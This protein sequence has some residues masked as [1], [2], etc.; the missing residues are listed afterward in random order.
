[1][2]SNL[3]SQIVRES[4]AKLNL[5][6][7]PTPGQSVA[8]G[9][10]AAQYAGLLGSRVALGPK[11][12]R[13]DAATGTL[14]G[15]IYMYVQAKAG[16]TA[17][18]ARGTLAFWDVTATESLYVVTPDA[19][20]TAA[21]PTLIA[22]VWLNAVT[23]GNYGWIQVAGRA[24]VL[25]DTAVT[26]AAAGNWVTAK[27]SPTTAGSADVGAAAG[28][29]TLAAYLGVAETLPAVSTISVVQLRLGWLQRQ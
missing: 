10:G 8:S 4:N 22:G 27:V 13:F 2:P 17:N 14:F 6:N 25:F 7:D 23:A 11:E 16:S 12:I 28:V 24:S 18:A 20:P 9:T 1:M 15:G 21:I 3:I 26:A 19:K 29:V 5:V